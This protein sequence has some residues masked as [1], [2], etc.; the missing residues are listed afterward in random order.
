MPSDELKPNLRDLP[1]FAALSVAELRQLMRQSAVR[2]YKRNDLIFMEGE[3]YAGL[4]L[5]LSGRVKVFKTSPEGKEQIIHLLG[6]RELFADVPLFTGGPYPVTAQALEDTR[7]LFIPRQAFLDLLRGSS[8]ICMRMLGAFAKRMRQLVNLVES[9]SLKDVTARLA[10]YLA[11]EAKRTGTNTVL[12]P[13]SKANLAAFLGTIPETLSRS[14]HDLENRGII[15]VQGKQI[16]IQNRS[17]LQELA[18]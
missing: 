11:D 2:G 7:L 13:V 12:L 4:Y 14:L 10:R 18:G 15:A 17:L 16:V 1:L 8:E 9:L 3:A 6:P 5:V